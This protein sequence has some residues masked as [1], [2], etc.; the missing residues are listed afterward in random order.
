MSTI[1]STLP[2]LVNT[3]RFPVPVAFSAAMCYTAEVFT[4]SI[5]LIPRVHIGAWN[6]NKRI[7]PAEG[8]LHGLE[9]RFEVCHV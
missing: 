7:A 8:M 5:R 3:R 2:F 1:L 9:K 6:P 4:A